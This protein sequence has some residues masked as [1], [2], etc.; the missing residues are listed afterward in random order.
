GARVRPCAKG[1][2][3]AVVADACERIDESRCQTCELDGERVPCGAV[4]VVGNR[5]SG[6]RFELLD[7]RCERTA[8]RLELEPDGLGR[9]TG[10]P[11]LAALRVVPESLGC[12]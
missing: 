8:A 2:L 7:L 5:C 4:R 9:L 6:A 3:E 11:Q 12:D 1:R 10:E